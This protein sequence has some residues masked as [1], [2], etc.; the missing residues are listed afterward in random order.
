[1]LR[2]KRKCVNTAITHSERIAN[3]FSTRRVTLHVLPRRHVGSLAVIST[4]LVSSCYRNSIT[5]LSPDFHIHTEKDESVQVHA[6]AAL[7]VSEISFLEWVLARLRSIIKWIQEALYVTSR[8]LEITVRLSPLLLLTP[9]SVFT[10]S[11]QISTFTWDYVLRAVQALGPAFVKL[12]QWVATR[13]DMFPPHVCHRF[14]K[15]HDQGIP[16]S[17]KDTHAALLEAFGPYT[18]KGL[19]VRPD[20]VIGC[21]SAAQVYEGILREKDGRE[22]K[23]AVKVLHPGF[24]KGVERD[25]SFMRAIGN[26]LHSLPI[27]LI[28]MVNLPRVTENFSTVLK[29]QADLSLEGD[30]L[31]KFRENFYGEGDNANKSAVLFPKPIWMSRGVLVEDLIQNAKPI[32]SFLYNSTPEGWKIRKELAGP[33][34]RAFLKMVFLDNFIH[35]DLHPG[36]VLVEETKQNGKIKRKVV[37]LDAGLATSL[38]PNDQQNLKDLFRAVILND[39]Y[40]AGKLMVERAKRERCTQI[41]GG[42]EA[43]AMGIQEIVSEFHDRRKR[44]LTLGAVRIGSLLSRVLD[45]CRI[46][47]VE[48][49]PAMA[50]IVMSTLVLEGLGRSLQPDLNLIDFAMPFVLGAGKI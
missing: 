14:S 45:L 34:L 16:H 40:N 18:D 2:L 32:S 6:S 5:G 8:S 24:S 23:V 30:N 38:D 31:R 21:G 17:W 42:K 49:D 26:L 44:G 19:L 22:R 12:A 35:C 29:Q 48:I 27:E 3:V 13:P 4:C 15:L 7:S 46:H 50:S 36:N 10:N 37:F 41:P 20:R 39:G 43:F 28:R 25:L 33:M 47:G 9:L 1:M 11:Q